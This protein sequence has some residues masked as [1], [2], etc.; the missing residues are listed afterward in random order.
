MFG[1]RGAMRCG[2]WHGMTTKDLRFGGMVWITMEWYVESILI[3]STRRFVVCAYLN[4]RP[5][6]VRLEE[7]AETGYAHSA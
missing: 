6:R 4:D 7:A 2:G 3:W 5:V 1:V